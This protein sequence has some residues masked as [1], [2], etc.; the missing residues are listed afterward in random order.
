MGIESMH[1]SWRI[2]S[3]D[4]I[5]ALKHET[6]TNSKLYIPCVDGASEESLI[7]SMNSYVSDQIYN[8]LYGDMVPQIVARA[9]RINIIIVSRIGRIQNV[10]ILSTYINYSSGTNKSVLV[11]K[12]GLHYDGLR[13]ILCDEPCRFRD[14]TPGE[15]TS[16]ADHASDIVANDGTGYLNGSTLMDGNDYYT[17]NNGKQAL[18]AS[19]PAPLHQTASEVNCQIKKSLI[20]IEILGKYKPINII[21]CYINGLSQGKL[22]DALLGSFLKSYDV[23]LL[24]ETW[25]SDLDDY[26]LDG[27]VYHNYPRKWKHPKSK[28]DSGVLGIFINHTIQEGIV[29]WAHTD[30]IITWVIL[31]KSFFGF[32]K[33]IYLG[34]VYIVPEGSTYLKYDDF[35]LLY[36]QILKVPDDSEIAL[37]GDFNA[38]TGV[39]PD[40]DIHVYGSNAGLNELLPADDRGV[41]HI[42]SELWQRNVLTRASKDKTII[43]RHGIHFL[44]LCKSTGMLILNGRVGRDK[45]IGEFTRDDTT[46][47]SVV[48]YV[49]STPKLFKI[50]ECMINFPNLITDLCH[51][52]CLQHAPCLNVKKHN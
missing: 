36:Q 49:I 35:N 13:R 3:Q 10:S 1:P 5:D 44:E 25:A 40:F 27:F 34:N 41:N 29:K 11:Y 48:D 42:I 52:L 43:N 17:P 30:D 47:K 20:E 26:A 33:Y 32:E 7:R 19:M 9:L 6:I 22:D 38:R 46:G 37:C 4:I 15:V 45:D 16:P 21:S 51:W 2:S 50:F 31:K 24:N 8:T 18:L 23:I 12:T 14:Q 39:T 28:R